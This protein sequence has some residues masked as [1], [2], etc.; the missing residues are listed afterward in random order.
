MMPDDE[1][2]QREA[3]EEDPG[4]FEKLEALTKKLLTVTKRDMNAEATR[5]NAN[6]MHTDKSQSQGAESNP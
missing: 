6:E 5:G 2:F 3:S 1:N 4:G